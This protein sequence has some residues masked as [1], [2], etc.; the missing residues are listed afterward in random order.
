[1]FGPERQW[2]D[3]YKRQGYEQS[4]ATVIEFQGTTAKISGEGAKFN[5]GDIT[6]TADGTYIVSGTLDDGTIFIDA[7]ETAKVQDV[8]K[9]QGVYGVCITAPS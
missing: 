4:T 6:I 7:P 5:D 8:Y 2:R 9:R 1:M 3:V